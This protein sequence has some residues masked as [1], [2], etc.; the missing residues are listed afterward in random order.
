[1]AGNKDPAIKLFG[2][3]IQLRFDSNGDC[4]PTAAAAST[5][6]DWGFSDQNVPCS[7]QGKNREEEEV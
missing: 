4:A 2:K 5:Y 3:M 6:A 1:M 7:K